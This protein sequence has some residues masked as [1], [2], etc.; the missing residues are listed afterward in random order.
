MKKLIICS[1]LLTVIASSPVALA[2]GQGGMPE[3][4]FSPQ[5]DTTAYRAV[6][7]RSMEVVDSEGLRYR[8]NPIVP[9]TGSVHSLS[10][11]LG[12][13]PACVDEPLFNRTTGHY[14]D[15]GYW[16]WPGEYPG[17]QRY[18]KGPK[19]VTGGIGIS[20]GYRVRRWLE[21]GASLTYAGF[22]QNLYAS[23]DRNVAAR[24]RNHYVTLMPYARFSWV[25]RRSVRLYSSLHLG[26]QF[27]W[28]KWYF[29]QNHN[30]N[31]L[32]AH[33]TPFGIRVGRRLF[34]YGEVG[35]GMRGVFVL[36]IGYGLGGNSNK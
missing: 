2:A 24:E 35:I 32:A 30:W 33:F 25:N 21:V 12:V 34:G 20:Y 28:Q 16:L 6:P 11:E 19:R 23:A 31:Y 15:I 1:L 17:E 29:G 26:V 36:G 18:Y 9:V 10:L 4:E 27:S 3:K 8:L 7:E 5:G 14:D 13:F 22:Y